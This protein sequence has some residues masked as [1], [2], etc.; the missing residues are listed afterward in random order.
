MVL[1]AHI[2]A[3]AA[4]HLQLMYGAITT[5][6]TI[7]QSADKAP[8]ARVRVLQT[9]ACQQGI[10]EHSSY[11]HRFHIDLTVVDQSFCFRYFRSL[12]GFYYCRY[13]LRFFKDSTDAGR[14]IPLPTTINSIN[15]CIIIGRSQDLS[16]LDILKG[17]RILRTARISFLGRQGIIITAQSRTISPRQNTASSILPSACFKASAA[18]SRAGQIAHYP[19][20]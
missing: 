7:R 6:R 11:I 2:A 9:C 20:H 15:R 13:G 5:D 19:V 1:P 10:P 4:V 8:S 18:L 3:K 12:G 16:A 17:R 14:I